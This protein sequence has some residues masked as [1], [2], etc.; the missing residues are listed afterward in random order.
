MSTG[1]NYGMGIIRQNEL[2]NRTVDELRTQLSKVTQERDRLRVSL[3]KMC[4]ET[5]REGI[6]LYVELG[7]KYGKGHP[8]VIELRGALALVNTTLAKVTGE[9]DLM[10]AA[11]IECVPPLEVLHAIDCGLAPETQAGIDKAVIAIRAALFSDQPE[12]KP[13]F[14]NCVQYVNTEPKPEAPKVYQCPMCNAKV[15]DSTL[16]A[17]TAHVL[18]C[19]RQHGTG[20]A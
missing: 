13:H 9:K 8:L 18:M 19:G 14:I 6:D 10:R 11:L 17:M 7:G 5:L 20:R 4:G 2:L 16:G 3:G 15:D 12:P 1:D